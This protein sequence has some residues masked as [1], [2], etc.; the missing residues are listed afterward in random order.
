MGWWHRKALTMKEGNVREN[1]WELVQPLEDEAT[2]TEM[3]RLLGVPLPQEYV[4]CV[5]QYNRGYPSFELFLTKSGK[6]RV[7]SNLLN[8][9]KMSETNI[10]IMY[11]LFMSDNEK[12]SELFPFAG[13]P[14][15]NYICFDMR[16]DPWVVVF[17][18]HEVGADDAV[19]AVADSF[20]EFL[21]MLYSDEDDD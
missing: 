13:D 5:R 3:E 12:H 1:V 11:D 18:N 17:W 21:G 2:I 20:T 15:G 4:D 10:F 6:E 7:F 16:T 19:D 8:Y 9:N 14:F